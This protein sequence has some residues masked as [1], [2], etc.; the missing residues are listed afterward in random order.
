[1]SDLTA[2]EILLRE[3]AINMRDSCGL[4]YQ[5][6]LA[7]VLDGHKDLAA[8]A[9][10]EVKDQAAKADRE[11]L[12]GLTP[13]GKMVVLSSRQA[14]RGY[15]EET[16]G[17]FIRRRRKELGLSTKELGLACGCDAATIASIESGD[18]SNLEKARLS[19]LSKKLKVTLSALQ[20][21]VPTRDGSGKKV[22]SKLEFTLD[23]VR[24]AAKLNPE[25]YRAYDRNGLSPTMGDA[26]WTAV[27]RACA[28]Q[29]AHP[30]VGF[31]EAIEVV[32]KNDQELYSRY[33]TGEISR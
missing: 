23:D 7:I 25:A 17:S 19:L 28:Y 13:S 15:K 1:M 31:R 4:S 8:K 14:A 29:R 18:F 9:A 20:E 2:S 5:E 6:A 16:L 12:D 33:D 11:M 21:L 24:E 3:Y 30:E 26:S 27:S 10:E 22:R 32:F